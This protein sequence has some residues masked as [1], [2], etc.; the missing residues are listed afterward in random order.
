MR[1]DL[2]KFVSI[3]GKEMVEKFFKK[4]KEL[5]NEWEE[6][7]SGWYKYLLNYKKE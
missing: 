3:E 6:G 1:I 5:Y 2:D 7:E 4:T